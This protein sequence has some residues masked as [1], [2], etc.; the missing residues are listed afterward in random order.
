MCFIKNQITESVKVIQDIEHLEIDIKNVSKQIVNCIKNGKKII[1]FGNGGSAADAQH[2][3]AEFIGRFK[4]ERSSF[5]AISLTTDTSVLTSLSNDY[6]NDIIFSRQCEGLVN[7]DDIVL[8]I[9][10]S[11]NSINVKKAL[12]V[13]KSRGAITI[14]LLGN[15][16]GA[17]KEITDFSLIVN[18]S[19]TSKIQEAHRVIYHI[20]CEI[21]ENELRG[22]DKK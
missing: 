7:L 5:P 11:G 8:G 9:S 13:S 15:N 2:I 19:I 18:S 10:T 22:F 1:I 3:A 20:I 21:V 14:G 12:E 17:I 16:G 6:S 4:E